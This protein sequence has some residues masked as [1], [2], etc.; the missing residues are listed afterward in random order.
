MTKSLA[1][2]VVILALLYYYSEMWSERGGGV[3]VLSILVIGI[4]TGTVLAQIMY[5]YHENSL[6]ILWVSGMSLWIVFLTVH[7]GK[8]PLPPLG[9]WLLNILFWVQCTLTFLVGSFEAD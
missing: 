2:L 1:Y 5:R 7:Y 6:A 9:F 8:I 4:G 3:F